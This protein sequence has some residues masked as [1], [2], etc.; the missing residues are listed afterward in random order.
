LQ[1]ACVT[2]WELHSPLASRSTSSVADLSVISISRFENH[3]D[4]AGKSVTSS[5]DSGGLIE[6]GMIHSA[7][8]EDARAARLAAAMVSQFPFAAIV[9]S[10]LMFSKSGTGTRN[11]NADLRVDK[12][13]QMRSKLVEGAE[14]ALMTKR[15]QR[16]GVE[17]F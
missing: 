1:N 3:A 15:R 11:L 8:I 4:F 2:S 7:G 17:L 14:G 5:W 12:G 16:R 10:F 9:I 6:S 13:N